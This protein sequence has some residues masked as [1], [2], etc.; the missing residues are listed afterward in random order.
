VLVGLTRDAELSDH[1]LD[2]PAV[3]RLAVGKL[4]G[5]G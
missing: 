1:R 3:R 2:V 4:P 5:K